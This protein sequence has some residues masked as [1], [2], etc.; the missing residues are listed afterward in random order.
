MWIVGVAVSCCMCVATKGHLCVW[1]G[2]W[3]IGGKC[4]AGRV[5]CS[6]V[7]CDSPVADSSPSPL[8]HACAGSP[9]AAASARCLAS[10]AAQTAA[11]DSPTV[12]V[13]AACGMTRSSAQPQQVVSSA[14]A[15]T[16]SHM[17]W[18][19]HVVAPCRQLWLV[20]TPPIDSAPVTCV[21]NLHTGWTTVHPC[22]SRC[23]LRPCQQPSPVPVRCAALLPHAAWPPAAPHPLP[24]LLHR[25][26]PCAAG[27]MQLFQGYAQSNMVVMPLA[28]CCCIITDWGHRQPCK[29]PWL[30]A[31]HRQRVQLC[32]S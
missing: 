14:P 10:P 16:A 7:S 26:C 25:R 13:Y 29:V 19:T 8:L 12:S 18:C 15:P 9:A 23:P 5:S 32:T 22:P 30:H 31:L 24:L 21:L 27:H 20:H 17:C 3:P 1:R 28:L 2:A 11:G 4:A 6:P